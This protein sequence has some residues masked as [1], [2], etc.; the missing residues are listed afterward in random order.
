MLN[1]HAY[2]PHAKLHHQVFLV[3]R[4]GLEADRKLGQINMALS[5]RRKD[6]SGRREASDST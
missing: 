1:C 5:L 2:L 4:L 6:S 3:L